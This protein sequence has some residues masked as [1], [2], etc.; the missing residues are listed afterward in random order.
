V[1]DIDMHDGD[2]GD[3]LV[4]FMVDH[5]SDSI[6]AGIYYFMANIRFSRTDTGWIGVAMEIF[7]YSDIEVF[8]I[9]RD[10]YT[11]LIF[12]NYIGE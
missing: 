9:I 5:D 11:G 3:A 12:V 4:Y 10:S 6:E 7:T 8:E 1:L 2:N